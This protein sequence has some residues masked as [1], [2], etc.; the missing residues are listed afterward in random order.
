MPPLDSINE[1]AYRTKSTSPFQ[2]LAVVES[3]IRE[4]L[5]AK[6]VEDSQ[7]SSYFF[8]RIWR[9]ITRD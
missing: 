8:A 2:S 6:R 4:S 5:I 3:E 1:N 9:D 7:Y